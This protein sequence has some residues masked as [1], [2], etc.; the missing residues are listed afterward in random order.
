MSR[1]ILTADLTK[2]QWLLARLPFLGASEVGAALGLNPYRSPFDLYREKIGDPSFIPF[3]GN[4]YTKWGNR[5]EDAIAQGFAEDH[6]YK[7]QKDNKI[8]IHDNDVLSC[9]LDRVIVGSNNGHTTPG[10]LE[11]KNMS[12]YAYDKMVK[13][14]FDIP[15][16]YYSQHQQQF[17][18]TGYT[19]GY[20]V[21]LVG[22][23]DMIVK[24][25]VP[26][27][28]YIKQQ[29]EAAITWWKDHVVAKT[30]P[31]LTQP[32]LKDPESTALVNETKVASKEIYNVH[33]AAMKLKER[34]KDLKKEHDAC[35]K[36]IQEECGTAKTLE[37]D[38]GALA[39]YSEF[40]QF[41]SKL[42][43]EAAPDEYNK[44]KATTRR[45]NLKE[46]T[47]EAK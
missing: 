13:N 17:G 37:Y 15:L 26:D 44:Y 24:E 40:Q 23:N 11:I 28:E 16:T 18:I 20:F 42:F 34:M 2:E 30:P 4:E 47:Y 19:W 45:F 21:M 29:E 3:E 27:P 1:S 39:Y 10:V 5:L 35:V 43:K 12:S 33:Q 36:Q 6:G 7:I 31:M 38:G 46:Y 9:S 8:R 22:G 32:D 41:S 25:M 14:E